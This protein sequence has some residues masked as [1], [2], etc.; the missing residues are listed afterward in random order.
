MAAAFYNFAYREC[1]N[2]VKSI[3][4]FDIAASCIPLPVYVAAGGDA[5]TSGIMERLF[6]VNKCI[7][8]Y[9]SICSYYG[10]A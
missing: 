4:A 8:S 2:F 7:I 5:G 1:Y 9:I 10:F 3:E 6:L